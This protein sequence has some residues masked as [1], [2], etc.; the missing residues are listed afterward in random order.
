MTVE[1]KLSP[2]IRRRTRGAAA[3][4]ACF[5]AFLCVLLS[6]VLGMGL[7]MAVVESTA[8]VLPSYQK[9]DLTPYLEKET[10]S[11]ED[12]DVLYHQTGLT[13]LGVD[14]LHDREDL[15]EFQEAFFYDGTRSHGM[16]SFT[17][18]RCILL[19]EDGKRYYAPLVPLEEGDILVT[20]TCHTFGW[21]NGHAAI[22]INAANELVLEAV[23]PGS[24]SS[25]GEANWFC[26]GT[27][28]MVLRLKDAGR[29]ER[30]EIAEWAGN[31]L[32]G[33]DYSLFTGFFNAKDQGEDPQTTHCS[34]LVW[35]AFYHFGYDIDSDGGPLV[36]CN[37]IARSELLEVVQVY[38]FDPDELW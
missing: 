8:R 29:E 23:G 4:L 17:T 16:A 10:L 14:A 12:Y 34:H 15:L 18:P 28:F 35:Q 19:D 5:A 2:S 1:R 26:C 25:R 32:I 13:R 37:D 24:K 38:G 11:E 22:V 21:R 3:A 31:D 33:L 9:I 6:V 36:T 20:S 30:E 27:N 7:A